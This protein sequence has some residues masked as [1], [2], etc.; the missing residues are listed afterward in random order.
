MGISEL[1][2]RSSRREFLRQ[3]SFAAAALATKNLY[4]QREPKPERKLG[5]ALLG[6]GKYSSGQLAPALRET[7]RCYLAGVITGHPEKGEQWAAQYNL[8]KQNIYTYDNLEKISDTP[9]STLSTSSR[10]QHCIRSSPFARRR[11]ANM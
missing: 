11:R 5:V 7:K 4:G 6:L 3:A 2:V 1:G 10:H 8:K 9:I